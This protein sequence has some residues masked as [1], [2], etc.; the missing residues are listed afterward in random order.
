MPEEST[1]RV[2]PLLTR[3]A[4]RLEHEDAET[5]RRAARC[6]GYL[7]TPGLA[8]AEQLARVSLADPSSAVRAEAINA[9]ARLDV[10]DDLLLH[11]AVEMLRHP[12]G[13][14]RARAGWAIGKLDPELAS[15]A[16]PGLA[17]RLHSDDAVDG[18]FG[19]AWAASRIRSTDPRAIEMLTAALDDENGDV[20]AEA[21]RALGETGSAAAGA[22]PALISV[23][24]DIDPLVRERAA[25]ALG[26]IGEASPAVIDALRPLLTDAL[27]YVRDASADALTR[28]G[29]PAEPGS[30]QGSDEWVG[31]APSVEALLQRLSDDNDFTRAEA[32]WLLGKHGRAAEPATQPL[33]AQ[34]LADRDS[35]ARW[36]A[37]HALGRIGRRLPDVARAI[38]LIAVEDDDPDVRSKAAEVLGVFWRQAPEEALASLTSAL[39]DTDAL[40]RAD[41]ATALATIGAAAERARG[42]LEVAAADTH[43][44]VAARATQALAAISATW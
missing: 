3:V 4:E 25:S 21:A 16:I 29:T 22:V 14:V 13:D 18:R 32:P 17:E 40:V 19:A 30:G 37:L 24:A 27:D 28:L 11:N 6:L 12:G 1:S 5:R 33:L 35:D 10:S 42:G 43:S 23:L 20:R 36:S 9:L 2:E 41:A 15:T 39:S 31:S 34:A 7:G 8:A 26:Q 38:A 44:G